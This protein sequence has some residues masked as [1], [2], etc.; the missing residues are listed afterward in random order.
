MFGFIFPRP[1]YRKM[2]GDEGYSVSSIKFRVWDAD[3]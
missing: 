3:F 2:L 1:L